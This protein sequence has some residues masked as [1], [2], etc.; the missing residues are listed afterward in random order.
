M[1]YGRPGRRTEN[2]TTLAVT[3]FS[4]ENRS[5]LETKSNVGAYA[6]SE[7]KLP[8]VLK[9]IKSKPKS[10]LTFREELAASVLSIQKK[11]LQLFFFEDGGNKLLRN[12][13]CYLPIDVVS[14]PRRTIFIA[15]VVR[16]PN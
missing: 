7:I 8:A 9:R 15:S 16:T 12:T 10:F 1:V 3:T 11:R 13:I 6:I 4:F 14:Y 5:L 2:N